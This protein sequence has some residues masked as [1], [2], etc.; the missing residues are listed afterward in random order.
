MTQSEGQTSNIRTREF[1]QFEWRFLLF[2]FLL[3]FWSGPGQTFVISLFGGHFREEFNLS[4]G[5]F[6][7]LYTVATLVSAS[8][9]WKTGPLVDHL[10]LRKFAIF[11]VC[12]MILAMALMS[13]VQGP[14]TLFAGILFV[15]FMGQGMLSHTAVTAMARRYE[16]ERGR[17]IAFA[18]LGFIAGEAVFP[19][20]IV[21]ALSLFDWRLIWPSIAVL[22]AITFLPFIGK[23]IIHTE[24]QD[25]KGAEELEASLPTSEKHWTRAELLRDKRFYMLC[26]IP[27]AQSGIITGLF[28]HQ[29]HIIE[30]KGWSF[31]WWSICF[32][33]FAAFSLIGGLMA[34]F[35]VDRLSARR[36]VPFSLLFMDL[37]LILLSIFDHEW[38]APFVM[39]ALGVGAGYTTPS[40]SSLW[41]ELYGTRHL[42]AIRSVA[43]VVMVFGSAL[44][45]VLMGFAFDLEMAL[46]TITLVSALLAF[47]GVGA[48][49]Q[50]LKPR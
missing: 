12:L 32:T 2:G 43:S 19:P 27:I 14:I 13:G 40:L 38:S 9:L 6:G 16:K 39:A 28:F 7:L 4:H 11:L 18:G 8:L 26:L 49:F 41:A 15:R 44:G 50:A 46:S 37:A 21:L 5:D 29:V 42:G 47:A 3:T 36:I 24:H 34:G 17:A 22:A 20:A 35:L 33:I 31:E 25:G 30:L 23:L 45:P 10:P 1:V 48:A